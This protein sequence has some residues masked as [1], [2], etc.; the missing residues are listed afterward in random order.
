MSKDKIQKLTSIINIS[1]NLKS[2]DILINMIENSDIVPQV[3]KKQAEDVKI[4]QS[5]IKNQIKIKINGKQ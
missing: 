1:K 5:E 2:I 3:I 4:A